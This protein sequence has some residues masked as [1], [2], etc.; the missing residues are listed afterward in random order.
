MKISIWAA[1]ILIIVGLYDLA[2]VFNRR[3][4][5]NKRIIGKSLALKKRRNALLAYLIV[6]IILTI[7]GIILL[8]VH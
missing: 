3:D 7:S 2:I 6:G 5:L 8:F 4:Q 1:I